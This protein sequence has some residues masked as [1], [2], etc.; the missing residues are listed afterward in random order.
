MKEVRHNKPH[1][2]RFHLHVV[3]AL[4][5]N[6]AAQDVKTKVKFPHFYTWL[7]FISH[8][9]EASHRVMPTCKG[10]R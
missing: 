10:S 3:C 8:S 5:I 7:P 4:Y 9:L 1:G 6:K 2:G